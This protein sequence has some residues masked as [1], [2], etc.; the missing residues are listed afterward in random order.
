MANVNKEKEAILSH[1]TLCAT[2]AYCAD[3]G[4]FRWRSQN[5][6]N[7]HAGAQAGSVMPNGYR[8]VKIQ[9]LRFLAHRLAW[10]YV[11]GEWPTGELDHIN[12]KRDDNRIGNLR[13][14]TRML[15]CWNSSAPASHNE[16][17]ERNIHRA[18]DEAGGFRI[19]IMRNGKRICQTRRRSLEE[20]I[21]C[22]DMVLRAHSENAVS[23]GG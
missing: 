12:Q 13:Q 19:S 9:Y 10:F 8:V 23:V 14:T 3:T 11:H 6:V 18:T 16:I 1:R 22:R 4:M 20:A 17:G 7:G 15:N 21:E 5:G 2:L